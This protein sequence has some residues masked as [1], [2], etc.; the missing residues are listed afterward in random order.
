[1]TW[2]Y[3]DLLKVFS[4]SQ[5]AP[6]QTYR[7]TTEKELGNLLDTEDIRDKGCLQ[8]VE[9]VVGRDDAPPALLRAL[10]LQPTDSD[11][12]DSSKVHKKRGGTLLQRA[13]YQGL[14]GW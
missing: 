11:H 5:S 9:I 13:Q 7:V 4:N 12:Q 8:L 14:L 1:M 6:S 2:D 3:G 10:G